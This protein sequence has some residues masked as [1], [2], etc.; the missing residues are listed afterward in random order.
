[1]ASYT[2][3]E[4]LE[5]RQENSPGNS[6]HNL[7]SHIINIR[8]FV[9]S[10]INLNPSPESNVSNDY[11]RKKSYSSDVSTSDHSS[12]PSNACEKENKFEQ[13]NSLILDKLH[14]LEILIHQE[15]ALF[16]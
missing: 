3:S 6:I 7:S 11:F 13:Q 8:D 2:Y 9:S 1:M 15:K 14:D 4:L 12:S 10:N 16:L 5:D